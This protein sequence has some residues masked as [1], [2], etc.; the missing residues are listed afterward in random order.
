MVNGGMGGGMPARGC[1]VPLSNYDVN[2]TED[3]LFHHEDSAMVLSLSAKA[4]IEP[5]LRGLYTLA[6]SR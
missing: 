6:P 3:S 1:F 2:G 5:F 4:R